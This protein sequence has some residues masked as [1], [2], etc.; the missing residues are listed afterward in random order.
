VSSFA[1]SAQA[2]D[3]HFLCIEDGYSSLSNIKDTLHCD[4]IG[5]EIYYNQG[6][7]ETAFKKPLKFNKTGTEVSGQRV[8][9]GY[10]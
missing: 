10:A 7:T 3:A 5:S 2:T 8:S 6:V 1:S 4:S 9:N